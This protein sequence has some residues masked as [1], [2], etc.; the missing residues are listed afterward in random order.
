MRK[1]HPRLVIGLCIG[2]AAYIAISL[3]A[4]I[5]FIAI[6][7]RQAASGSSRIRR[8]VVVIDRTSGEEHL[9]GSITLQSDHTYEIKIREP[10][11]KPSVI[12]GLA[13]R[14]PIL[15]GFA[16]VAYLIWTVGKIVLFLACLMLFTEC[17]LRFGELRKQSRAAKLAGSEEDLIDQPHTA[18]PEDSEG[19]YHIQSSATESEEDQH[20]N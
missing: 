8:E 5:M 1:K 15:G 3:L 13:V 2:L 9:I 4:G 17:I 20:A 7:Q 18:E 12:D 19:T 16:L 6:H 11:A 10:E 14:H